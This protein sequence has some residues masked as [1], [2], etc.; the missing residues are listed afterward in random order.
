MDR[1][2]ISIT[3]IRIRPERGQCDLSAGN[4]PWRAADVRRGSPPEVLIGVG[5][6]N[7]G[8]RAP[9]P[10]PIRKVVIVDAPPEQVWGAW[11]TSGGVPTFMGYQAEVDLR[12]G[13][14][15]RVVFDP[16]PDSDRPRRIDASGAVVPQ[17]G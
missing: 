9:Y 7:R 16:I 14:A 10:E 13:G 11:A 8:E 3:E 12:P 1:C 17:A 6:Q 2:C 4:C 5:A 15:F